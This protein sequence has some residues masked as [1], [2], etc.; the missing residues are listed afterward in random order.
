[1][2]PPVKIGMIGLDTSHVPS[3]TKL[4]NDSSQENHVR[5][6]R[7]TAAYPGGSKDFELSWGRV[8]GY[9][10]ELQEDFGVEILDSPAAVAEAV[11][12]VF[13]MSV[14]G[15]VHLKQFRETVPFKRPTFIDKPFALNT[16]EAEKIFRLANDAGVVVMSSSAM[17]FIDLLVDAIAE[18]DDPVLG[19]NVFGPMPEEPTQPG[20]FWY[21]I[22]TMEM[23]VTVMGTGCQE[24]RVV[25][26]DDADLVTL[27]YLDG[28]LASLHGLRNGTNQFGLTIQRAEQGAQFI[29]INVTVQLRY[30]ALVEAIMSHLPNGATPIPPVETLEVIR[31]IEAANKSRETDGNPV[32]VAQ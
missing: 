32:C 24:V 10:K 29:D 4:L 15:R 19:C 25:R 13:I 28:R 31:L 27:R 20:L 26:T 14:D 18:G 5:G 9:T 7:V 6:G 22:H 1:M 30:A 21:G 16:R 12:V 23:V 2:N 3:F 8:E 11:D 17:R